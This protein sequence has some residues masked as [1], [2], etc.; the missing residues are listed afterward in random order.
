MNPIRYLAA[1]GACSILAVSAFQTSCIDQAGRE[2]SVATAESCMK[3]HN[4]SLHDDYAGPGLENPHPFPGDAEVL[5]CTQCHGGNAAGTDR[6]TSHVPPPPS[7]GDREQQDND[8][9]AWFNKLT[10]A[11]IDKVPDYTVNGVTYTGIDYLQFLNPGD[12]RV[13]SRQRGC[14]ECHEAH[15]TGVSRGP[16]ATSMGI[17]SGSFYAVGMENAIPA[18]Q[19]L[20]DDNAA[21]YGWR[22]VS[23]PTHVHDPL[24][25]GKIGQ[26]LEAPVWSARVQSPENIFRNQQFSAANLVN[27][28]NPDGSVVTGS[29]LAKLYQEQVAFTCGDCHLGSSGANNRYGDFRPSGCSAC[30]MPYSLDGRS[31]S[32][33][34]N[35][36]KCEPEDP[37]QIDDPERAHVRSHRI[38]G[39]ARTLANGH[40]VTGI[41]DHTCAGC[42]Q[43]SNRMVMQYWGIRLDQNQDVRFGFQYPANPVSFQTTR[44]DTRLFDPVVDNDTFNGRNHF[45]YLLREDYDGDGRDDTP[46]DVHYDAGM[47]CV[48]GHGSVDVHGNVAASNGGD[49]VSRMGHAITV[50][51]EDC[52]GTATAYANTTTAENYNGQ[53][54]T[55][56]VDSEGNPLRHVERDSTGDYWLT[57]KL[58]GRRHYIRQVRDVIVNNGKLHP[59]TG[60]AIYTAMGSYAMGR[61]DG[62]LATGIGSQQTGW[63]HAGFSHLDT[64]NCASCH[65]SWSNSCIGCHLEGEYD[66]GNNF[67]NITGERIV[68]RQRFAEFVY[69]SPVPFFLGIGMDNMVRTSA[70][71]TKVF[72][73]YTDI[74]QDRTPVFAF[75]DRNGGG[76]NPASGHPSLGHNAFLAHSIRGRVSATN[77]GPR[78]CV[79]CHLTDNSVSEPLLTQ[80]QDFRQKLYANDFANLPYALLQQHI[81]RNPGNQIDS[82]FFVHMVAGL[83]TGLFLFDSNGAAQNP[84]DDNPNRY[85]SDGVAPNAQFNPAQVR[86]DLDR[87]VDPNG[88]SNGSSNQPLNRPIVGPNRRDGATDPNMAGP[89]GTT[90]ALRLADPAT[91]IVLNSW[92]DADR[93]PKGGAPAIIGP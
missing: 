75:T 70:T 52:H 19:G 87:V 76:A 65:S 30:H 67:S 9:H 46:A 73:R 62:D 3:C 68:F 82:P 54:A 4:G 5:R 64:M 11:G 35:V 36:P 34:P 77:E 72:F 81:G 25:D 17:F 51:C 61:D 7:I 53:T 29:R 6:L 20:F 84:L 55:L 21:D 27:D 2:D 1:A 83:G 80:Y 69:Q 44:F 45:Q 31:R 41:D 47:G 79:S 13:S 56:G 85:G 24:N 10:L 16:I 37:D 78:Y 66:E 71:N 40:T 26:L 22:A 43:G 57:S 39:V 58:D 89:L 93:V 60:E 91:G 42:H 8:A 86:Y 38:R 74:N 15:A 48:D 88:V 49:I 33:D 32:Q 28:V 59:T 50:R 14:G 23:D 90:L 92:V 12:L 18:H 63:P